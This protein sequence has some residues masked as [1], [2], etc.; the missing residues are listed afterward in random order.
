MKWIQALFFTSALWSSFL[1]QADDLP[2][3]I[4]LRVYTAVE[5]DELQAFKKAF[6]K[7]YPE[8]RLEWV[9]NSTGVIAAQ[10]W[11]EKDN[12][13][14]DVIWGLASTSFHSLLK[15]KDYFQPYAP[16]NFEKVKVDFRDT[17]NPPRW[18][19]QR[20]WLGAICVNKIEMKKKHLPIPQSWMD[21][22]KANY[23]NEIVM[24]HPISSGTGFFH[25][26]S[27]IK[28]YKEPWKFM[29]DLHQNMKSYVHSGS[30]PCQMAA[31]GEVTMGLSFSSRAHKLIKKGAPLEIIYPKD[32]LGWDIEVMA[33]VKKS[34]N[35]EAAKKFL[36]WS[37]SDEAFE[38][39]KDG[40]DFIT[41]VDPTEIGLPQMKLMVPNHLPW[42]SENK[43]KILAQWKT[44]FDAKSESIKE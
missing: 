15:Q 39:Y 17:Q 8:I 5:I 11:A 43:D 6:E 33:L 31:Q 38:L 29:K 13:Q 21:L 22:T 24:P 44:Q 40:S 25:V 7:K 34:K 35:Q 23:K 27:W 10:L 3:K 9:R 37:L 19:G 14:A 1:I 42:L 4:T 36:D 18:V 30:K 41:K 28:T 32:G 26:G 20:G 2:S 16:Q 12:P